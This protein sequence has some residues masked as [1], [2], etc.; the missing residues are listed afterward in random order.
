M[1]AFL[2]L[3]GEKSLHEWMQE[4]STEYFF[5]DCL[6]KFALLLLLLQNDLSHSYVLFDSIPILLHLFVHIREITDRTQ[7]FPWLEPISGIQLLGHFMAIIAT[8]FFNI[9]KQIY[10]I[11]SLRSVFVKFG[12]PSVMVMGTVNIALLNNQIPQKCSG[13]IVSCTISPWKQIIMLL[14]VLFYLF[15]KVNMCKR[16]KLLQKVFYVVIF[17]VI[18]K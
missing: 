4:A 9:Q 18:L 14:L 10:W 12:F 6:R 13:F 3:Q 17:I 15:G 16:Q 8:L 11:T 7:L 2:L 1:W 5:S